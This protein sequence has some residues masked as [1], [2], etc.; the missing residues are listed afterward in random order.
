MTTPRHPGLPPARPLRVHTRWSRL[1][2]DGH[3]VSLTRRTW[4]LPWGR[5][6]RIPLEQV[7][8]L[9]IPRRRR[10]RDNAPR[11]LF[12]LVLHLD[13]GGRSRTIPLTVGKTMRALS[14]STWFSGCVNEALTEQARLLLATRDPFAPEFP[15]TG[16]DWYAVRLRRALEDSPTVAH[17]DWAATSFPR[18]GD[19]L[20]RDL[21]EDGLLAEWWRCVRTPPL[22]L[23]WAPRADVLLR[24]SRTAYYDHFRPSARWDRHFDRADWGPVLG[25]ARHRLLKAAVRHAYDHPDRELEDRPWV[26]RRLWRWAG[27]DEYLVARHA[28]RRL[29]LIE[30]G[31]GRP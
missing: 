9:D 21:L 6:S 20:L 12:T 16:D 18:P 23:D 4:P 22:P 28:Q 14:R 29:A 10:N 25:G 7:L 31:G 2:F 17:S 1:E 24:W 5:T 27:F 3:T 11:E 15:T 30:F 26:L 19:V 13:E 8:I